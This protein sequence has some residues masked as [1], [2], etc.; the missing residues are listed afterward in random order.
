MGTMEIVLIGAVVL[1]VFG[2]TKLPQLGD[3][4]GKAIKNFKRAVEP[5]KEI[6]VTAKETV[7][8]AK[9]AATTAAN[10]PAEAKGEAPTESGD[11][12]NS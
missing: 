6:E 2:S 11:G 9:Q 10:T 1:L 8:S 4:L 7:S 5:A 12:A 3:G